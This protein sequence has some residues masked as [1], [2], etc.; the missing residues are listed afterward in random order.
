MDSS[1]SFAAPAGGARPVCA[2][3]GS[4]LPPGD[5][6]FGLCPRCLAVGALA[7]ENDLPASPQRVGRYDILDEMGRGGMGVV[8]RA[9]DPGLRR[10]VALKLLPPGL[11]ASR[12]AMRRFFTEA[13]AAARLSHPNIVPIY[14]IGD[15][16]EGQPFL[17]MQFIAG[18]TLASRLKGSPLP[19][20]AAATL[21]EKISHAIQHAHERGILHRDIK[22]GNIL[23]NHGDEPL[24]ADFGLARLMEAD[25]TLTRPEALLGTPAY[26]APE[27]AA[28]RAHEATVLA[29]IY[30]LGAVLYEC[31]AGRPPF[32][33][34]TTAALLRKIIEEE[35]PS[36]RRAKGSAASGATHHDLETICLKCL[37][38]EPGR[39]YASAGAL[40]DD[41]A[42][43]RRGE[44]I[45]ARPTTA[46]ERVVKWAKRRPLIA[47]LSA[48]LIAVGVAGLIGVLVELHRARA[49]E[50]VALLNQYAADMAL[51][52]QSLLAGD[53]GRAQ[54]LLEQYRMRPGQPDLRGWEWGYFAAEANHSDALAT[55][56][57]HPGLVWWASFSPEGHW[58]ATA[59]LTGEVRLWDL[60]T[61]KLTA[62]AK[63]QEWPSLLQFTPDGRFLI[64]E[65]GAEDSRHGEISWWTVPLL[66]VARPPLQI[67]NFIQALPGPDGRQLFVL[68]G[69]GFMRLT[70][71]GKTELPSGTTPRTYPP[72][73]PGAFSP[74]G[75]Y[76]AYES[77]PVRSRRLV[78]WDL[79]HDTARLFAG[80]QWR[81]G[82]PYTISG[83]AFAPDDSV[84]ISS[85][86][87][88]AV[89]VWP[90]APN[91]A[92]DSVRELAD[93]GGIVNQIAF[94]RGGQMLAGGSADETIHLWNAHTWK[95]AGQL[96]GHGSAVVAMAA[97]PDGALLASGSAD[98]EVKLWSAMPPVPRRTVLP[99]PDY[100]LG[101]SDVNL[102]L[103][104][105][106]G[107]LL[108]RD[109]RKQAFQLWN[110]AQLELQTN[111]PA[112]PPE[113]QGPAMV[114]PGGRWIA[115]RGAQDTRLV[116]RDGSVHPASRTLTNT[117]IESSSLDGRLLLGIDGALTARVWAAETGLELARA[118]LDDRTGK[119]SAAASSDGERMAVGFYSGAV[120]VW[121]WRAGQI[122]KLDTGDNMPI[123][124]M[125]FSPDNK[126][127]ATVCYDS[128]ARVYDLS[129]GRERYHITASSFELDSVAW[130]PDGHRLVTGASDGMVRIWDLD[131]TPVRAIA[132]L[133]GH[134]NVVEAMAFTA[135]GSTLVT[136]SR[137]SLRVWRT[138]KAAR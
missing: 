95:F 34:G 88:G 112:P 45:H 32:S 122:L 26:L 18:G 40:A 57:R 46:G 19:A 63:Q 62:Q 37:E 47:V 118:V 9:V 134:N 137:D 113:F 84:L 98:G 6:L 131:T 89:R 66:H 107:Y 102:S 64:S 86:Y 61:R 5:S 106:G 138:D 15:G 23:L 21:L 105:E 73:G 56:G 49:G 17:A 67:T 27:L 14:E 85:G 124:G 31:L 115:F 8:F 4:S 108:T 87:D 72:A 93:T 24:V 135:D 99:L 136:V 77:G 54:T 114:G 83:L 68:S 69:D 117:V 100:L 82:F 41:L 125:A 13:Q 94:V 121:N 50:H 70:Q 75:S 39:R 91:L 59:D 123:S 48:G 11:L 12:D 25:S 29:D 2:V 58:L 90:L 101:S 44:P 1:V 3:C 35:P 33:A 65:Q 74:D 28:G 111:V 127:L 51:A 126:Q 22:P 130:S 43:W 79:V 128:Q 133:P 80:H 10:E 81:T 71:D 119:R 60:R 132:D 96:R 129:T 109:D 42:R 38:K 104:P 97:S 120:S 16:A 103:S 30:A 36:L 116:F 78:A 92:Q 110:T 76:F 52:N 55:L 20:L 53:F 7:E